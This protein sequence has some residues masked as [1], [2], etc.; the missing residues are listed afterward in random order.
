MAASMLLRIELWTFCFHERRGFSSVAGH[1]SDFLEVLCC[2]D[3]FF[4]RY[5]L[6]VFQV[7]HCRVIAVVVG[8]GGD[9]LRKRIPGLGLRCCVVTSRTGRSQLLVL[10][11]NR[12]KSSSV[13]EQHEIFWHFAFLGG[14]H[15]TGR[16]D[17]YLI[18][19]HKAAQMRMIL[20]RVSFLSL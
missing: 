7:R 9:Y 19:S 2:T 10:T 12:A 16:R 17:V 3:M 5:M 6:A 18:L 15:T 11:L 20:A 8:E 13:S 4:W 14:S 1:L